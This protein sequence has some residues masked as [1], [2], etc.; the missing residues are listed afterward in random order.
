MMDKS[1][2]PIAVEEDNYLFSTPDS[3][4]ST[5]QRTVV[6]MTRAITPAIKLKLFENV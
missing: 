2:E 5:L 3:K 4:L 1:Q 6:A